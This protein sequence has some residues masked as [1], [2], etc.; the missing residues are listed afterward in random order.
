M[1]IRTANRSASARTRLTLKLL[2]WV[3]VTASTGCAVFASQQFDD[4]FGE[5]APK[6]RW[7]DAD[8]YE[9]RHYHQHVEPILEQ[10]C[11]H[12]HACY[13][14]PCQLKLTSPLGIDRGLHPEPVYDG[15]RLLAT[16]PKRLYLDA[17]STAEWREKGFQPVLNERRNTSDA[18]LHASVLF[19]ALAL[20]QAQPAP[21]QA[22]LPDSY[23]F[24]LSRDQQ[25]PTAEQYSDFA[26]QYPDWGMPYGLPALSDSEYKTLA[27]WIQR[28]GLLPRPTPL[29]GNLQ[30]QLQQWEQRFN[31]HGDPDSDDYKRQSLINRYIYEHIYLYSLY[32]GDDSSTRFHLV[33][34]R[35]AP[36]E[37]VDIIATRR[38]YDDPGV[39]TPYYR[40]VVDQ[41]SKVA[42][43][44]IPFRLNEARWDTWHKLFYQPSYTVESLPGYDEKQASNPFITFQDIPTDSRYRFLLEHSL[45]TIMA[46]IKGPVCHGQVAV[47][48]INEQFWVFF[49][50]P[51]RHYDSDASDF[52]KSQAHHLD[53][54]AKNSS[55]S[56]PISSW[57]SFSD[58][59]KEYLSAKSR[60]MRQ[61]MQDNNIL[62]DTQL[63]WDGDQQAGINNPN[64]AL[65]VMRHFDNATVVQGLLG[66]P[67]KT[68]WLIDY[69]LLE[70]IHYLLVAG[71]DVYGNV[72]HQLV[73]RLYMDFLRMEGEMNFLLLLP[74]QE[75]ET[76][77]RHW[78]RDTSTTIKD[79]I[80]SDLIRFDADST[81][82]Y[83]TNQPKTELYRLL[84][85]R[86]SPVLNQSY[87]LSSGPLSDSA[88]TTLNGLEKLQGKGLHLLPELSLVLI[89]RQQQPVELISLVHNRAHANISS[90][91][92]EESAL[93][94]A[95][96][97]LTL[98]RGAVG[99]YPN[100]LFSVEE[101]ALPELV[102]QIADM[103]AADDY[104]ALLDRFGV[105]RSNPTFWAVSD[106]IG[107]LYQQ[108]WPIRAGILDYN[109]LE[110]R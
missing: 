86:L 88:I 106:A 75:R 50:T 12:C 10:R 87:H 4:V 15:T 34:S 99:D 60:F 18:N 72:G 77:R 39:A 76:V 95:E 73:T 56:L 49:V 35:T 29:N 33:R 71:F 32:L 78:Y 43:T 21:D 42:K 47:N 98:A 48:V 108:Q 83:Q 41:E 54:P 5:S 30:H 66:Q 64:A 28:G 22:V 59:Q 52:L 14:A 90:L 1:T 97:T 80:F 69:P 36:G 38:P 81:I 17:Q 94:P 2:L 16:A 105:R 3:I 101:S 20:R 11:V 8:S 24:K 100:V 93:R 85:D 26:S 46:F 84:A 40:L 58:Q 25:C 51:D 7:V 92:A 102:K 89:T 82:D 68:A 13:D 27:E 65:T 109:R 67:P 74:Q 55:N 110:N 45:E 53:L 31:A 6:T 57:I 91:L 23:D 96:D 79:Y 70:R 104:S 63:V 61:E 19:R 62:L 37:P 103:Q 9:G 44:H 107:Q